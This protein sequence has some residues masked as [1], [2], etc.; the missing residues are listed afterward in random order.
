MSDQEYE[1][2]TLSDEI[3][4][5]PLSDENTEITRLSPESPQEE[6]KDDSLEVLANYLEESRKLQKEILEAVKVCAGLVVW[7]GKKLN[8][9]K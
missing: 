3:S 8:K 4:T 7:W 2:T 9:E 5:V 6:E 1:V